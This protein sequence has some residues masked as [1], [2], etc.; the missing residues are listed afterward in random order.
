MGSGPVPGI[1]FNME[2]LGFAWIKPGEALDF[3]A[4][5]DISI[6]GPHPVS[7]SAGNCGNGAPV[8]G[9]IP[10]PFSRF[11]GERESGR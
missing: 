9:G 11:R 10:M 5:A 1:I 3:F 6:N 8:S 7:P 2:V 4:S